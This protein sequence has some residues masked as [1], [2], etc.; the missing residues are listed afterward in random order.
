MACNCLIRFVDLYEW[1][2]KFV[3]KEWDR[4]FVAILLSNRFKRNKLLLIV[5]YTDLYSWNDSIV[6]QY[7]Q[8]LFLVANKYLNPYLKKE[9]GWFI[10][11]E[12]SYMNRNALNN[13]KRRFEKCRY[14]YPTEDFA[15][16]KRKHFQEIYK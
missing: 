2:T 1:N 3:L 13:L 9:N 12:W 8:Q 4:K 5:K 16:I 14:F 7:R 6:K 15:Q 11:V 10:Y